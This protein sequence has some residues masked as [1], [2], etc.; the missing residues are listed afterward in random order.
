MGVRVAERGRCTALRVTE[1]EP[2]H[3]SEIVPPSSSPLS[4]GLNPSEAGEGNRLGSVD[5]AA[6]ISSRAT[7]SK[8]KHRTRLAIG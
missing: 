5:W 3:S 8:G 6:G 7:S 1:S 4:K 2:L